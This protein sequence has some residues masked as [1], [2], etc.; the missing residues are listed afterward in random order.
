MFFNVVMRNDVQCNYLRAWFIVLQ[1]R[2]VWVDLIP[3]FIKFFHL[4]GAI[5]LHGRRIAEPIRNEAPIPERGGGLEDFFCYHVVRDNLAV[6]L[7]G[8]CSA[9]WR[10]GFSVYFVEEISISTQ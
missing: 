1:R 3:R 9:F 7:Y 5:C 8:V 6:S 10:A 2:C 4:P